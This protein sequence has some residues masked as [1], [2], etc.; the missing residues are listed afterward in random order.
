MRQRVRRKS[1]FFPERFDIKHLRGV[2]TIREFD[3]RYTVGDGGYKS[4][5]DYY[6]R[7]SSLH[8]IPDIR[9]PA[10][11]IHAQDDPLVPFEPF[12]HPSLKENPYLIFL[13]PEHGGHVGFVGA[14]AKGEDRF[15]VENRVV[16]FC[17]LV[18]DKLSA[19]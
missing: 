15:W 17:K 1:K 8:C 5:E 18:N 6:E 7:A 11:I 9:T 2:R 10:L 16:E 3:E 12:R 4:V 13:A 14:D 19:D